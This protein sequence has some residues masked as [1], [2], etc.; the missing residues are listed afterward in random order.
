MY[1]SNLYQKVS[2]DE[3]IKGDERVHLRVLVNSKLKDDT[4]VLSI[5]ILILGV[6]VS[7]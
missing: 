3:L 1:V 2:L 4:I 7:V 5:Y 6:S